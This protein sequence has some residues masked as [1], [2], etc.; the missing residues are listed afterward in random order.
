MHAESVFAHCSRDKE[1][2]VRVSAL[3]TGTFS[4]CTFQNN[5]AAAAGSHEVSAGPAVGLRQGI[6]PA[7]AAAARFFA[8]DFLSSTAAVPGDTSIESPHCRVYS[9]GATPTMWD[10]QARRALP[11]WLVRLRGAGARGSDAFSGRPFLSEADAFF[12]Q[13]VQVCSRCRM[14]APARFGH[15][16]VR[17]SR[18]MHAHH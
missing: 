9:D 8:C 15:M 14:R 1:S 2:A 18:R 17:A 7:E 10:H 12:R 13:A 16:H 11:P 6:T 5:S 3:A 4:S